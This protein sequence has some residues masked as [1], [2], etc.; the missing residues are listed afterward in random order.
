MPGNVFFKPLQCE[1]TKSGPLAHFNDPYVAFETDDKNFIRTHRAKNAG[2]GFVWDKESVLEIRAN[3]GGKA[4]LFLKDADKKEPNDEIGNFKV[5]LDLLE[6]KG[7]SIEWYDIYN[8]NKAIGRI[9]L[10]GIWEKDKV[11]GVGQNI[12]T[13]I[14]PKVGF[15]E[16][17]FQNPTYK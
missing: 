4:T 14:E 17:Q 7:H 8:K 2:E 3:M 12:K 6:T 15:T 9:Q 16:P 13:N 1:F 5:D 11:Y 10:E